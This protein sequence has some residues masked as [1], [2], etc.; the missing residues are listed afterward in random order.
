M[1]DEENDMHNDPKNWKWGFIYF[2]PDDTRIVVL[3]RNPLFGVT[4]NFGHPDL[5]RAF[6][7]GILIVLVMW[8][9]SN[10]FK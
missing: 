4:L 6:M 2:N 8:I 7:I 3:K 1:N 9:V 10:S 5:G